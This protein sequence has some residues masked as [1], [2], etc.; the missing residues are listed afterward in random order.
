MALWYPFLRQRQ[1]Q[2]AATV[3]SLCVDS[4]VAAAVPHAPSPPGLL[5]KRTGP[6]RL[7]QEGAGLPL[8]VPVGPRALRGPALLA[9]EKLTADTLC[10]HPLQAKDVLQGTLTRRKPYE[11]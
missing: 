10:S 8:Q 11:Q 6:A 2:P 4:R 7:Q 5:R 3:T 9:G 1:W